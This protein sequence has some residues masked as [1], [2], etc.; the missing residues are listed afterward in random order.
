M[1]AK[2]LILSVASVF[3]EQVGAGLS[4]SQDTYLLL[5]QK[6]ASLEEPSQT[7]WSVVAGEEPALL[8]QDS[9]SILGIGA[10]APLNEYGYTRVASTSSNQE[11][12]EYF[13]RV[14]ADQELAILTDDPARSKFGSS[15][16]SVLP[17]YSGVAGQKSFE[18][19]QLELSLADWTASLQEA[20][21][22]A[23]TP[24]STPL[25]D[26][27]HE[28][29]SESMNFFLYSIDEFEPRF[30][31]ELA[32]CDRKGAD[33]MFLEKLRGHKNRV[34]LPENADIFVVPCLFESYR[35]C[36]TTNHAEKP[37]VASFLA[38][39][40][41]QLFGASINPRPPSER[42]HIRNGPSQNWALFREREIARLDEQMGRDDSHPEDFEDIPWVR[43]FDEQTQTC[44]D[45]VM[46]TESFKAKGG[47]DHLWVVA[48]WAM[49]FGRT[50][51]SD[52]FKQMT[53]GRIETVDEAAAAVSNRPHVVK[54]S[55][56]SFVVPYASDV[57]YIED[58][59]KQN[60]FDEWMKR[61]HSVTFR[62]ED[63]RYVLFCGSEP[64]KGADDATALRKRSLDFG[65]SFGSEATIEME[66][67]P[68]GQFID[69]MHDAKFC[70]VMR[71]DTPST[72]A[73]YDA[74]ASNCIPV[75][76]SDQWQAVAAPF[77]HGTGGLLEGGLRTEDY[78][79]QF[80]E[81]RFYG[82]LSGVKAELENVLSDTVKARTLF[83][84]M[85][86][87][88]NALLWSK[89]DSNVADLALRSAVQCIKRDK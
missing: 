46:N 57:A 48:D 12:R 2:L 77:S 5:L 71:G 55:Q 38:S 27:Q 76:I 33:Y 19:L 1:V 40:A 42:S 74:L 64:C 25:E 83:E 62:F 49:N 35:R 73:F 22:I 36:T 31:G 43:P 78:T 17:Y 79:L 51:E 20:N 68:M 26:F 66:R 44:L 21:T 86:K 8:S 72:H 47:S 9:R 14:A 70:L 50:S 59:S 37:P 80:T 28:A 87:H 58:W 15:L 69:E 34:S 41:E 45:K 54:Q 84:Q 75:L 61:T 18:A 81:D 32:D 53:I 3:L 60:S 10:N 85:Q 67:V 52:L 88:R 56:C 11:M 89:P 13:M 65:Q 82:D 29:E 6:S 24:R 4:E 39:V 16:E 63:R 7:V 23:H 30:S